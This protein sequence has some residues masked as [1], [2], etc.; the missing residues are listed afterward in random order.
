[1]LK[2]QATAWGSDTTSASARSFA[3]SARMRASLSS[4]A[5]PAKWTSCN[6]TAPSDEQ[7]RTLHQ[8]DGDPGRAGKA[9]QPGE[10]LLGRWH[11]FVLM[12]IGARDDESGQAAPRQLGP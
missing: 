10:P 5:S 12:A 4:A 7:Q 9:G 11:V 6:V 1:M 3:T 2:V 8:H